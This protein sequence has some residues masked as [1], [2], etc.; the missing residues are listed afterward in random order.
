MGHGGV[1][2]SLSEEE[3]PWWLHP[4]LLYYY[5][6]WVSCPDFFH[7]CRRNG[8]FSHQLYLI[9]FPAFGNFSNCKA[10]L[11]VRAFGRRWKG[12]EGIFLKYSWVI[13]TY[14]SL[15]PM[16]QQVWHSCGMVWTL[17]FND[18]FSSSLLHYHKHYWASNLDHFRLAG[19]EKSNLS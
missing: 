4:S 5:Y 1:I 11:L 10:I 8:I 9:I 14:G 13:V 19:H 7:L 15:N 2:C 6:H 17:G 3:V 16:F 12:G 18:S